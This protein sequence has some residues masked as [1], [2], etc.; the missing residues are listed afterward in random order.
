ML[1]THAFSA[2]AHVRV[3]GDDTFMIIIRESND[4]SRQLQACRQIHVLH[5]TGVVDIR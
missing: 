5:L 3:S 4:Q 1:L 2:N